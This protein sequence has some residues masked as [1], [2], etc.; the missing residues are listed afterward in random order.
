M[1][2][3]TSKRVVRQADRAVKKMLLCVVSLRVALLNHLIIVDLSC[4]SLFDPH[5]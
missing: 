3:G 1:K 2:F 5:E 4:S